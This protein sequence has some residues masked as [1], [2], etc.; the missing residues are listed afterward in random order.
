MSRVRGASASTA[1]VTTKVASPGLELDLRGQ[2]VGTVPALEDYYGRGVHGR[3]ALRAHHSRQ[4][5]RRA[6]C[7][8]RDR[9]HGHPLVQRYQ[10][11]QPKR[12]ATA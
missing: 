11:G 3:A 9:L 1:D 2:R 12:V 4:G 6:A 8:H 7:R 5:H 10:T